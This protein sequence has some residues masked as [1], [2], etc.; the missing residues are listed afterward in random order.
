MPLVGP[1]VSNPITLNISITVAAI[2]LLAKSQ[3]SAASIIE[4]ITTKTPGWS[5]TNWTD[6]V[7]QARI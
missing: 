7:Y 6:I 3:N 5:S 2:I 4:G 1:R